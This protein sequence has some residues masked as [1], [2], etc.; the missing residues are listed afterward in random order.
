MLGV[1]CVCG[2]FCLF[3]NFFEEAAAPLA[4]LPV[5]ILLLNLMHR[6]WWYTALTTDAAVSCLKKKTET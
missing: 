4:P 3:D 1:V 5:L 6:S 2:N